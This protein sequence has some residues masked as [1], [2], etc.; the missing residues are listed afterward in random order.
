[1]INLDTLFKD[2][3]EWCQKSGDQ[4]SLPLPGVNIRC[5]YQNGQG[6]YAIRALTP[7][8]NLIPTLRKYKNQ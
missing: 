4:E 5:D 8:I 3:N 2:I 7:D 1:M 6:T